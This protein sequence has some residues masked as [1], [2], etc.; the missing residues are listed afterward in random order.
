MLRFTTSE[1]GEAAAFGVP[2][3]Q[4]VDTRANIIITPV[5]IPTK[6]FLP[7]FGTSH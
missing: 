4:A 6:V 3:E 7:I 1:S 2:L 5:T